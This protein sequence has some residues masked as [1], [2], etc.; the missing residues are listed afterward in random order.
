[1]I[2][3]RRDSGKEVGLGVPSERVLEK[4]RQLGF[5]EGNVGGLRA[6]TTGK[7]LYNFA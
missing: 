7:L 1:M 3:E 4:P 2:D 5:S 6:A